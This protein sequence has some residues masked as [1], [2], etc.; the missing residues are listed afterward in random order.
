[1]Q[2][3]SGYCFQSKFTGRTPH[4]QFIYLIIDKR[5]CQEEVENKNHSA[6]RGH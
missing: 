6:K 1:M 4:V 5:S 3:L 2:D